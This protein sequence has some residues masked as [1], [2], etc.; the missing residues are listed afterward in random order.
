[1]TDKTPLRIRRT[2][3]LPALAL[4][5]VVGSVDPATLRADDADAEMST[6]DSIDDHETGSVDP[7]S[8]VVG[9]G[10]MDTT[11]SE[12]PDGLDVA[13]DQEDVVDSSVPAAHPGT[14]VAIDALHTASPDMGSESIDSGR[15]KGIDESNL[16]AQQLLAV[17]R[18]ERA[19]ANAKEALTRYGDMMENDY[20]RGAARE[21][22]IQAR[23]QSM[24]ALE[25]ARKL[26]DEAMGN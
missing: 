22:I 24:A 25:R 2:L 5:F 4:L 19:Q 3:L 11:G 18:L 26:F 7:D 14:S 15:L 16:D 23:D 10:E 9:D 13:S 8:I 1:M 12:D 6:A 21:R 20:P 17:R